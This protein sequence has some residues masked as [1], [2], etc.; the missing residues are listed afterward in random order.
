MLAVFVVTWV[1]TFVARVLGATSSS[2]HLGGP[3][4]G[5]YQK[6]P[7]TTVVAVLTGFISLIALLLSGTW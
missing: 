4:S 5:L 1:A 2:D 7:G 6:V 3:K